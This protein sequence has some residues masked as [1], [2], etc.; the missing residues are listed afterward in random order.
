MKL[1]ESASQ[2]AGPYV[3]IGLTPNFSGVTAV[4]NEDLGKTMVNAKTRGERITIEGHIFD[5]GGAIVKDA[6]I[7]IWQADA[8]GLYN[9]PA[10]TRG[11]TDPEFSGWGRCATDM[12]TGLFRFETVKPGP[13]PFPGGGIQAPH[14]SFWI[15]ARGINLGLN[16]R[17]YFA[18]DKLLL[19]A[20]P[21]L[22][23]IEHRD[24]LSTLVRSGDKGK[25][26]FDIHLQ[27]AKETIFFDV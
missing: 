4:Y 25:Y 16:T 21:V 26:G 7:E 18:E 6:L 9:S 20:D 12:E 8:A 23:R 14:V 15:V 10:D 11:T 2:T 1:K 5:G 19:E 22:K 17:M 27:G 3:H 24:R 13:V